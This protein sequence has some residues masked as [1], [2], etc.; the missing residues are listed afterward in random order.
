[1]VI[2]GGCGRYSRLRVRR[3]VALEGVTQVV[4][5]VHVALRA[6]V[7]VEAHLALPAHAHD[8]VLL[9]AVADDVGVAHA[10]KDRRGVLNRELCWSYH[11]KGKLKTA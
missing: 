9:A 6:Q 1:M 3:L 8:A 7:V 5:V 4:L 11:K 2:K 10:C